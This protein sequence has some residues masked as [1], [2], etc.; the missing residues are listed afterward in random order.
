M[1][2]SLLLFCCSLALSAAAQD[3]EDPSLRKPPVVIVQSGIAL[4]WFDE[5]YKSFTLAAERPVNLYNHIGLQVNLFFPVYDSDNYYGAIAPGSYEAGVFAKCFFHGRLSGRRSKTYYGPDL[6]F[7]QRNYHY[8]N[9]FDGTEYTVK[10]RTFKFL[11]RLGWQFH[12]GPA[13]LE[14]ATPFGLENE[15]LREDLPANPYYGND[16]NGTRFIF[17]PSFS[18]GCA[19]K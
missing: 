19:I 3:I 6:R 4:Q 16:T 14:L 15:T 12:L 13:I 7:G 11:A 18:I 8:T 1:K 17:A 2:Q 5:Q 10:A 9:Y